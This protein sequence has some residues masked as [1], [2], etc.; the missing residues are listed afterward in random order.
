[1]K[2]SLSI[3]LNQQIY[4]HSSEECKYIFDLLE[5]IGTAIRH[6]ITEEWCLSIMIQVTY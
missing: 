2:T 6:M 4:T 5:D 3:H 1:M